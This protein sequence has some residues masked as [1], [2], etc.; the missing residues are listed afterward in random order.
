MKSLSFTIFSNTFSV[1]KCSSSVDDPVRHVMETIINMQRPI[2]FTQAILMWLIILLE[3]S[4]IKSQFR[5]KL[6]DNAVYSKCYSI[7]FTKDSSGGG[8]PTEYFAPVMVHIT[9]V[10]YKVDFPQ[11]ASLRY[12]VFWYRG[13]FFFLFIVLNV[14]NVSWSLK[15]ISWRSAI[16]AYNSISTITVLGYIR[17]SLQWTCVHLHHSTHT[18]LFHNWIV[19]G[20]QLFILLMVICDYTFTIPL[21]RTFNHQ[22][23]V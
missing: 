16:N 15:N 14:Q 23:Q 17:C 6:P 5:D 10:N 12:H 18:G 21:M 13:S 4:A 9:S 11:D 1:I 20:G 8:L 7:Q 3:S 19:N 2:W 22:P